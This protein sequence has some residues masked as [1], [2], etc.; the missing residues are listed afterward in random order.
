MSGVLLTAGYDR[1]W[2]SVLIAEGLR[3][4]GYPPAMILIAYP[5][6]T[7]RIRTILRSRG[8]SA[9]WRYLLRRDTGTAA[10][11]VQQAAQEL[12]VNSASL[13]TWA[14]QHGV[15]VVTTGDLNSAA[16]VREVEALSPD[17]TAYS[18]G[19][20]LRRPFIE[21]TK[22]RILNAHSGPLPMVRGMNAMEWSLLL[23]MPPGVTMHLIDEGIDTGAVAE[24]IPVRPEAG[25]R[26][27]ALRERLVLTGARAMVRWVQAA[28][29]GRLD[30]TPAVGPR[31]RQCFVVAPALRELAEQRLARL[32]A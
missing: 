14:R 29:E 31:E 15:R 24:W 9:I 5:M 28:I 7:K 17:V 6:S 16:T 3:R 25:D 8:G 32:S 2:H 19:G 4:L 22:R 12:G 26:L 18:G 21:A 10:S 13:R 11:L 27:D 23:G 20:I 1:A 30:T